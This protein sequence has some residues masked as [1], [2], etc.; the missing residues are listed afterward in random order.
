MH[1]ILPIPNS[2]LYVLYVVINGI[3]TTTLEELC[4][5]GETD[6]MSMQRV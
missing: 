3:E 2:I 1:I 6:P 5:D 4:I